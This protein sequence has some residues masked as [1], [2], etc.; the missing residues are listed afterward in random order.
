[1]VNAVLEPRR[2]AEALSGT[3]EA[4][5]TITAPSAIA[6]RLERYAAEL[7]GFLIVAVVRVVPTPGAETL[8]VEA[9]KTSL[10]KCERCWTYRADVSA[11]GD[12]AGVCAR[13]ADVLARRSRT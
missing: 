12:P 7:S 4:E 10:A 9:V 1:A 8:S 13:C 3:A 6:S 5:V 2:A 11:E